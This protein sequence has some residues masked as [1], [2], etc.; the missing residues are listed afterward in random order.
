MRLAATGAAL[1][2]RR[3]PPDGE[4]RVSGLAKYSVLRAMSWTCVALS[5]WNDATK[6]S[7]IRPP[8]NHFSPRPLDKLKAKKN[9]WSNCS[10]LISI[11]TLSSR[12]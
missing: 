1:G 2:G 4:L 3:T 8:K 9:G 5:R 6:L 12:S 10:G 7:T 11:Q